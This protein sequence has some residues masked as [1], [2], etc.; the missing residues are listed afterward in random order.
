MVRK[1]AILA[2]LTVLALSAPASSQETAIGTSTYALQNVRIVVSPGEV[3]SN[4]TV[5]IQDGR[6]ASVGSGV[7]APAGAVQLD[8]SGMTVYPGL[9]EVASNLGLP[10]AGAQG[11]GF[12]GGG[13]PSP[14]GPRP[15]L[16]PMRI[17]SEVFEGTESD[18][19]TLRKAG[20]TTVGLAFSG[21]L[22][23][24]QT[25][26]MNTGNG[27]ARS[28][29]LRQPIAMQV[30]LNRTRGGYPSTLMGA[31]AYIEQS[32]EDVRYDLRVREAFDSDPTSAPRPSFDAE[33]EALVPAVTGAMPV[34]FAASAQRDFSRVADLA[35]R[36]GVSDYVIV[37][38]QEGYLASGMLSQ[39]GKPMVVSL[40]YPNPGQVS[41]RAFEYHVAPISG[42]DAVAAEADSAVARD[43]RGNAAALVSAG[44]SVALSTQGGDVSEMR[45][46]V[47]SAIE[48]GLSAD[49]A[50]RAVT[51]TPASL[52][53]L[54]G[55]IG[56]VEE[57]KLANLLVTDGDLF[58]EGTHVLHVFVEGRKFDYP[59]EAATTTGRRGGRGRRGGGNR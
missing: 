44:V 8:M 41:G 17:A 14:D 15:E 37:G 54:S 13:G 25:A 28:Q 34:W 16:Q 43:L 3:I 18:M 26:A 38:G 9:I 52:L 29:V 57:G 53:G 58:A 1:A 6:I 30:A 55:A 22:F 12:G 45:A 35:Q 2:C 21:G 40:N 47:R 31:L 49:D 27:D 50:L 11:F 7:R 33:H 48:G 24:G 32:W 4:G 20:I 51:L 42:E 56:S 39:L 19:E 5:V 23:P 36:I 10:S 59:A 46:L